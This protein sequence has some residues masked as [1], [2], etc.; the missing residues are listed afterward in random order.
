[1]YK[2]GKLAG[3]MEYCNKLRGLTIKNFRGEELM[4]FYDV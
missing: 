4:L 1:M 2:S 3:I